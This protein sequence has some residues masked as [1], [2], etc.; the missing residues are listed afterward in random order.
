MLLEALI[1]ASERAANIA[2]KC[3]EDEH[4]FKLLIEEKSE[5]EA[6]PRF[7]Q[8]FKTLADVL[9]QETLKHD[10][11][12]QYPEMKENIKGEES[13]VF[14]NAL[15]ERISVE[16]LESSTQTA[17]LL[18]KVL[19]DDPE[20][21]HL[22]AEEVHRDLTID[23]VAT[24]RPDVEISLNYAKLGVWI[25]P[26]DSTA[27]YING[28]K[29]KDCQDCQDDSQTFSTGGLKCVTVLI[30][31]YDLETGD[32][33]MGIVNQPFSSYQD[34]RWRGKCYWGVYTDTVKCCSITS[35]SQTE[36]SY[37]KVG[38]NV[39]CLS[40]S[41]DQSIKDKLRS[42]GFELVEAPGAGYKMLATVVGLAD[43]YL[44]SKSSTFKWDSCGPHALL[45]S[46]SGDIVVFE[47]AVHRDETIS[48][49]YRVDSEAG[50]NKI[51]SCCN[52][53]GIIAFRNCSIINKI[54]SLLRDE[55]DG[56]A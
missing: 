18:S 55:N 10:I 16:K 41:E 12:N 22:L 50:T 8:D 5:D 13:N 40:G 43:V 21:A 17:E 45:R 34:G 27:E 29:D 53:G 48:V 38:T 36:P 42:G 35:D 54:V 23:D 9:I 51:E 4:L 49:N 19:N 44:L 14:C 47:D 32:A 26:I 11:G 2:R 31:V 15:G 33:I 25:D 28:T 6:N 24:Q 20:A 37:V 1:I 52:K 7:V 46:L 56:G 3:R 39:V 30:G